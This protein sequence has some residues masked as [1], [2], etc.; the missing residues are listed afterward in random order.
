MLDNVK[1][2]LA[3]HDDIIALIV[4]ILGCVLAICHHPDESKLVLGGGLTALNTRK[5][6]NG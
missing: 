3:A 1:K 2:F 5:K 6:D 4:L